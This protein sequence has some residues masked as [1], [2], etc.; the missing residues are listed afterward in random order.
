M[1]SEEVYNIVWFGLAS[2]E[3]A[4][5]SYKLPTQSI[6]SHI[7]GKFPNNPLIF[8][9]KVYLL[10]V[11]KSQI[12]QIGS[13]L[14][15]AKKINFKAISGGNWNSERIFKNWVQLLSFWRPQTWLPEQLPVIDKTEE[16]LISCL[17]FTTSK[18]LSW[19][20]GHK[21]L[22]SSLGKCWTLCHCLCLCRCLIVDQPM[23]AK[24]IEF[25]KKK[26]FD[27][28][29]NHQMCNFC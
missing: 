14:F 20:L 10:C 16:Y 6:L 24:T 22:G 21:S 17:T 23:S 18:H 15:N 25:S 7:W 19:M 4:Y 12:S 2:T 29:T 27:P 26:L 5:I 13:I 8:F 3:F 11:F 28:L 1:N 9:L